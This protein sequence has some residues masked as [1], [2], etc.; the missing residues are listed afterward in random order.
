MQAEPQVQPPVSL[1]GDI[2]NGQHRTFLKNKKRLFLVGSLAIIIAGA[3]FFVFQTQLWKQRGPA[4]VQTYRLVPEK[5][6]QSAMI[7]INLPAGTNKEFAKEN[8]SFE[9]A[10]EGEW[11]EQPQQ[12]ISWNWFFQ[13]AL[14]QEKS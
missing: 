8:I 14:A 3:G 7:P 13:T 6:S 2:Q 9:P 4:Y 10:I 1:K 12:K 11:S 5:I